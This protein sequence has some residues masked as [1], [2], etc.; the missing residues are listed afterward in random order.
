MTELP[1]DPV[2]PEARS[3]DYWMMECIQRE[4]EGGICR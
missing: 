4:Q 2:S 3:L 1:V